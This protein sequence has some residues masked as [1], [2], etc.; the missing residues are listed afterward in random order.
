MWPISQIEDVVI[1]IRAT[2]VTGAAVNDELTNYLLR[3]N[4]RLPFGMFALSDDDEVLIEHAFPADACNT[5]EELAV[6]LGVIALTADEFD[7]EIV[8][9]WGACAR[10]NWCRNIRLRVPAAR[11]PRP[12]GGAPGP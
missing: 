4:D 2:L 6:Y 9:R 12:P 3:H 1:S 7:D 10:L 8:G 5:I 11:P